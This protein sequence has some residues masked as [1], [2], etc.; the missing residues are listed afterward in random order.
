MP[1]QQKIELAAS[2][3]WEIWALKSG[4][5]SPVCL[6]DSEKAWINSPATQVDTSICLLKMINN[7]Y[8]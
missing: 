4:Q 7:F 1:E 8:K 3:T 6:C 5:L 2:K